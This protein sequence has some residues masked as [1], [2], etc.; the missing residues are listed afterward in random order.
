MLLQ[1]RKI[2]ARAFRGC[3]SREEFITHVHFVVIPCV[4]VCVLYVHLCDN[5]LRDVCNIEN[6]NALCAC[7]SSQVF[8][9]RLCFARGCVCVC[10]G[11]GGGMVYGYAFLG[12]WYRLADAR[13]RLCICMYARVIGRLNVCSIFVLVRMYALASV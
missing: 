4:F 12:V 8:G 2:L 10:V 11:G 7:L 3:V 5:V 13:V 1:L 6:C 9:A